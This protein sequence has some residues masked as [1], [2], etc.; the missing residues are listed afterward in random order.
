M[1][2]LDAATEISCVRSRAEAEALARRDARVATVL[3]FMQTE[4]VPEEAVATE[5]QTHIS[6]LMLAAETLVLLYRLGYRIGWDGL[7]AIVA[8]RL[9]TDS[10]LAIP[11]PELA[12]PFMP[13]IA[14]TLLAR[15]L[16]HDGHAWPDHDLKEK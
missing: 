12:G 5:E 11:F 4:P 1:S 3:A 15:S 13:R 14:P 2:V 10:L 8:W 16:I 9:R 6:R 7:K